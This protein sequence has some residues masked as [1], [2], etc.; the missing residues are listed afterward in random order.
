MWQLKLFA[1]VSNIA[2]GGLPNQ[3]VVG[4][5]PGATALQTIL[6]IVFAVTASVALLIIVIAGFRYV[7]SHGDPNAVTQARNTILY[8]V[9]GL[10]VSLTA[11]SIVTFVVKGIG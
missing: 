2:P 8:A 3:S 5:D 10:L 9:I 7:V 1:V 6:S 4:T 11:F